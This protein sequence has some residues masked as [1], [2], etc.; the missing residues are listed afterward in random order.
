M[1]TVAME[2]YE[3]NA[4]PDLMFR[5]QLETFEST[6]A[7]HSGVCSA[8]SA[9]E[10]TNVVNLKDSISLQSLILM[11]PCSALIEMSGDG[12]QQ[13]SSLLRSSESLK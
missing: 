10:H 2:K 5:I 13:I 12:C 7:L 11:F 8:I 1:V 6:A 4:L 9:N 3:P